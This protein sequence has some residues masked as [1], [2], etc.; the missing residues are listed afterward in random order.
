VVKTI[1]F[2]RIK[3]TRMF[4]VVVNFIAVLFVNC[5]VINTTNSV[6]E[7]YKARDFLN[8]LHSIPGKPIYGLIWSLVL[9][10][11]LIISFF[12]RETVFDNKIGFVYGSLIFDFITS[13]VL[14]FVLGFNFNGVLFMVFAN[15]IA[16]A[17]GNKGKYLI[18][19]IA[20]ISYLLTD[21]KLISLSYRIYDINDYFA[22]YNS[23][24][25][26]YLVIFLNLLI[27][28]NIMLFIIYCIFLIQQQQGTIEKIN[29][30]NSEIQKANADLKNANDQLEK[31]AK[32]TE[33]MG[34]TRERN[35]L[36][37]EI[38]D[39]LGHTL[40]GLSVGIDA[41]IATV[42][43]APDA[44]KKQLVN[45]SEVARNGLLEIRKSV[46]EL[47]PDAIERL[48]LDSAITKMI[49]DMKSI[50]D[51]EIYFDC[52]IDQLK[53]DEDEEMAIYRVIQE[54][55]TNAVRHGK[56]KKIWIVMD[57]ADSS[58][59]LE[60]KDNGIGCENI[61]SG[62]GTKHIAERIKML[63]GSVDFSSNNGFC[64][65]AEIPIRWGEEY[66]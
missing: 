50:T 58:V 40:T 1:L 16:Y 13:V 38:H 45:L 35:R 53:F 52:K 56:A 49:T 27:S 23:G 25:Q 42:D 32:I 24:T 2:E 47:K 46:S 63:G 5:V 64:V 43:V 37:R 11:C 28:L 60:I 62:F 21:S 57:K 51:V 48:N 10:G 30:L 8:T 19:S 61:V 41:C 55:L 39:T 44:T 14:I 66:D 29:M 31:Y 59:K 6:C 4:I 17:K 65:K 7:S 20:L 3:D 15:V 26:Q 12:L 9:F 34:E 22:Y 36:A 54:S 18:I 33:H